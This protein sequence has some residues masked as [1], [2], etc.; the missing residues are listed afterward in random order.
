[1]QCLRINIYIYSVGSLVYLGLSLGGFGE[2]KSY[3]N[4]T[5][6]ELF[7]K[8]EIGNETFFNFF[9]IISVVIDLSPRCV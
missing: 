6:S 2:G 4:Y 7:L 1:M 3:F 5:W 9:E 8:L